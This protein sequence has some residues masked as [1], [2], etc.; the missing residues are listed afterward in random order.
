MFSGD[1][2]LAIDRSNYVDM[3]EELSVKFKFKTDK[4]NGLVFLAGN[5]ED[6]DFVALQ[7]SDGYLVYSFD[8]G[9]GMVGVRS[10]VQYD[11]DE[12]ILVE[13]SRDRK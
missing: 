1:G 5:P 7:L 11:V 3:D 6:G 4:A 9:S 10:E 12:W 2:Y 13:L 8:L